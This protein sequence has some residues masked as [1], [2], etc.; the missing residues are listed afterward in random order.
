MTFHDSYILAQALTTV[1]E[2]TRVELARPREAVARVIG[3]EGCR[4]ARR[5]APLRHLQQQGLQIAAAEPREA[6]DEVRDPD[7]AGNPVD[8]LAQRGFS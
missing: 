4:R 7:L 2:E 6:I 3:D 5:G 8:D 1:R